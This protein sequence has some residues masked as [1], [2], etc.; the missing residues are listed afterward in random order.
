MKTVQ[1]EAEPI[2]SF[3]TNAIQEVANEAN[4]HSGNNEC[5][6]TC[7]N[8]GFIAGLTKAKE[9]V[10]SIKEKRSNSALDQEIK[11]ASAEKRRVG[12]H[13]YFGNCHASATLIIIS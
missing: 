11:V 12:Y 9:L 2:E 1:H 13:F 10:P 7:S 5:C 8:E 6:V 3:L 4:K